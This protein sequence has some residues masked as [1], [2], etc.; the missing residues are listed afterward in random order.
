VAA[1]LFFNMRYENQTP[2]LVAMK[3][4]TPT[5]IPT[6]SEVERNGADLFSSAVDVDVD[7]DDDADDGGLVWY[8]PFDVVDI[9][10]AEKWLVSSLLQG[11]AVRVAIRVF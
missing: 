5:I 11:L 1:L 10:P 8:A 7:V 2:I 9:V 6:S 3:P 4:H